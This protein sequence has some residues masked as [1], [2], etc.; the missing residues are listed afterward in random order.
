MARRSRLR[1]ADPA[2]FLPLGSSPTDG[3]AEDVQRTAGGTSR[4]RPARDHDRATTGSGASEASGF[5]VDL[6][7]SIVTG[8]D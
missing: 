4:L 8:R 3:A 6:S 5:C 2:T 1:A 7:H